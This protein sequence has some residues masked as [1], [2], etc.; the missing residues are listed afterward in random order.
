MVFPPTY[1]TINATLVIVQGVSDVNK[2][3]TREIN[4]PNNKL[5]SKSL[6][7]YS[8]HSFITQST[9]VQ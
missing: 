7:K 3:A 2:P 6:L 4:N 9:P 1:P 8:I 5:L